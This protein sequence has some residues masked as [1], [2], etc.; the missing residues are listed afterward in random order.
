M[1]LPLERLEMLHRIADDLRRFLSRCIWASDIQSARHH[2]NGHFVD[3]GEVDQ[4]GMLLTAHV[5][6][7]PLLESLSLGVLL[8]MR[9][10]LDR[11]R[12]AVGAVGVVASLL[13]KL[14][15]DDLVLA[16]PVRSI[17]IVDTDGRDGK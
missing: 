12:L 17:E 16:V 9:F 2:H 11:H 6:W 13:A 10:R 5:V 3:T 8:P 14:V 7:G 1:V 4:L 15:T